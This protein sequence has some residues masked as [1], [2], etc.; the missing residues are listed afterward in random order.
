MTINV[1]AYACSLNSSNIT[2]PLGD[3]KVSQFK[4]IGST[5]VQND[6]N[7]SMN[8]DASA[9]VNVS[10]S[11]I[12]N[13]DVSSNDVIAL[14]G[15][16]ATDVAS[17][18]GVQILYNGDALKLNNNIVLKTSAGGQ[19]TFSFIARYYQTKAT[20][21]PGKANAVATLNLTYQ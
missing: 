16:G 10:M 15:A 1:T 8:C 17:G 14:T 2:V 3:T 13:T 21:T 9:R 4:T 5:S 7:V 20:V 19:E 18:L 12:A 11:A 6:F